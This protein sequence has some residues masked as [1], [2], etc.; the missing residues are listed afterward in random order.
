MKCN[1]REFF[2]KAHSD[3]LASRLRLC[4]NGNMDTLVHLS[5]R[6]QNHNS[7]VRWWILYR[8]KT[9]ITVALTVK[10]GLDPHMISGFELDY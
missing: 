10:S 1:A 6:G 9:V 3:L 7:W 8:V 4:D 5:D 2:V